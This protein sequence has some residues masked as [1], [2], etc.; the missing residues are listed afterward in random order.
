MLPASITD[1][2][3]IGL[4]NFTYTGSIKTIMKSFFMGQYFYT[5]NFTFVKNIRNIFVGCMK[6]GV[7]GIGIGPDNGI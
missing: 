2:F 7:P 3:I 5:D 6:T 1:D 4:S